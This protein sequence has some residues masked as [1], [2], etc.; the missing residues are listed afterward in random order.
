MKKICDYLRYCHPSAVWNTIYLNWRCFPIKKAVR[1]PILCGRHIVIKDIYRGCIECPNRFAIVRLGAEEGSFHLHKGMASYLSVKGNGTNGGKI[2]FNGK[3]VFYS[4]FHIHVSANGRMEIGDNFYANTG[5]IMSC[6][7]RV[8]IGDEC[9][10]GW[11]VTIIDGDGHSIMYKGEKINHNKPVTIGNHC[12]IA[13][14]VTITK[15]VSLAECT[16][17]P[18][19]NNIYKS[20]ATPFSIFDGNRIIRQ[21]VDWSVM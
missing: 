10:V 3:C 5:L 4:K 8:T 1:L 21:D 6:G 2:K 11:N 18:N 15:G 19:G 7:H 12:W 9:M 17:V 16:I 20:N 14:G 13:S